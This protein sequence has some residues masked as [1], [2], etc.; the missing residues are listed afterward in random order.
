MVGLG[1]GSLACTAPPGTAM[2]F[3]ELNPGVLRIAADTSLF[4]SLAECAPTAIVHLGDARLTLEQFGREYDI[5]TLDA[6]SSD[7][8]PTHLLTREAFALY[9]AHLAPG[10]VIAFHVSNRFLDLAPVVAALAREPGSPGGWRRRF[11]R[12]VVR[13]PAECGLRNS[14]SSP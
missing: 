5:L 12:S 4:R 7:A 14:R 3:F 8:I 1:I 13:F 6:F 2:T 11:C 9:R 10:G